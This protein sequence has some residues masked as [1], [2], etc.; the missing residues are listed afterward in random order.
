MIDGL[1][2]LLP[3]HL[4]RQRWFAG[5]EPDKVEVVEHDQMGERLHWLLVDAD[6]ARYQLLVGRADHTTPD[7]VHSN[8][9]AVVGTVE[10]GLYYDAL[11]DPD[12]AKDLLHRL[13]P[14]EEVSR[15]RPMGGE[16]SNSSIVFDDRLVL[17]VFRRIHDGANPDIEVTTALGRTGFPHVAAPIATWERGDASLGVVQPFLAG[18]T[19]GWLLALTS[20]R[21][22]YGGDCIDPSVCGGDFGA[23]SKRLGNVTGQMHVA[24]AEAFG[25][26]AGDVEGWL[27]V[28]ERQLDRV[29]GGREWE[30][31]ARKVLARVRD[32]PDSPAMRVHGD[33]HLGQVLRTDAGWF[34]LDFEGE[35]ARPLAERRQPSSPLKDVAGMI[36]SFDYA[37]AVALRER[38]EEER[39]THHEQARAW[40]QR[41]RRSFLD[42]Y[43]A[44]EGVADLMVGDGEEV[45]TALAA[46]ELDKAIYE[47]GYELAHRP[48]WVEIPEAAI[49]RLV[50][51]LED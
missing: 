16:Q 7:F 19:D 27:S 10:G 8:D 20:L 4:A 44:I 12:L 26:Q 43:L 41:N 25:R 30:P 40:E 17:K 36:R 48:D 9:N 18:G 50:S 49:S 14:E 42:G 51:G 24:L 45:L 13:A 3:G 5:A 35:P 32:L 33:Y 39:V 6:G 22:L 38:P 21:D 46:W 34:V 28:M 1:L 31:Q 15:V 37:A 23:E 11:L 29:G 47:L 2:H